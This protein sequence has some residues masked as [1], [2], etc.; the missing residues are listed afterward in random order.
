MR[1]PLL[2]ANRRIRSVTS[3]AACST[4]RHP[5]TTTPATTVASPCC[6]RDACWAR[7]GGSCRPRQQ[8]RMDRNGSCDNWA[9]CAES[10]R[11]KRC[12]SMRDELDDERH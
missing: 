9:G 3:S 8:C 2:A 5:A 1:R 11:I 10:L 4:T 12:K 7:S 6:L